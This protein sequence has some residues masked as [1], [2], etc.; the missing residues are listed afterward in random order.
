MCVFTVIVAASTAS[1]AFVIIGWYLLREDGVSVR[2][3]H[4]SEPQTLTVRN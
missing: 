2:I 1:A 4:I 3:S